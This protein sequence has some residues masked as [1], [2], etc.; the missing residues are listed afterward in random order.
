M[1]G[2]ARWGVIADIH[3]NREALESVLAVLD[4]RRIDRLLC[5]G[6]VVGYNADPD[7]CVAIVRKRNA[8]VVER[9]SSVRRS[10]LARRLAVHPRIVRTPFA[11]RAVER[12]LWRAI[13]SRG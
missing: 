6:D 5:L 13:T 3:G 4:A 2:M 9:L 11:R 12:R 7:E 1:T 8:G 10:R